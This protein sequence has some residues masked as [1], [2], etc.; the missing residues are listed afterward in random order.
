M[1]QAGRSLPE[2]RE[3]RER[4]GLFERSATPELC[5]EVTLQ[6]VRRQVV[7]GAEAFTGYVQAKVRAGAD[8][9]Q[10]HDSWVGVLA[11]RDYEELVAPYSAR[12]L[13]ALD[14]PTIHFGTGTAG[15]LG[16]MAA[17]VGDVIG[18][19]WRIEL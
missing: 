12:I 10:L 7:D 6:P 2:Y 19:D 18:V 11:P 1:R 17:S 14:V 16:R 3:L 13:S 8:V 4:F 9:V 5:A 15:L